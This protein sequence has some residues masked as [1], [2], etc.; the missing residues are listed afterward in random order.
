MAIG[1]S[2]V[3][4]IVI[5][6]LVVVKVTGGSS[7]AS[8]VRTPVS[9]ADLAQMSGVPISSMVA[10]T[11]ASH[12]GTVSPPTNLPAST[13]PLT[14]GGKPEILYMGAEYC[15]Y[16]AAER[17]PLVMALSKFGT[18]SNLTSTKSSSTDVN[19]NTPTFSFFG[20]TYASP[21]I[22]FSPVE[23]YDRAGNKLQTPTAE[24][25]NLINT[26]DAPPYVNSQAGSIPFIDLGGRY[27]VSGTQYDG[28]ALSN[29]SFDTA[30]GY[31]TSGTTATSQAGK[32]AAAH[33][34]GVICSLTHDQ[35]ASVCSAVPASLK[36]GVAGS[37]NQGSSTGG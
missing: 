9:D 11:S 24:Q 32:A 31:M 35:P 8:T 34:V 14:S 2:A 6:V 5:A 37:G 27:V 1:A 22:V 21:Y 13:P 4:V 15:P 26:Y 33:L 16:C 28:S 7:T 29:M 18:F 3:V 30:I 36:T 17:W 10:A 19:P 20:S 12:I 23:L 25:Q